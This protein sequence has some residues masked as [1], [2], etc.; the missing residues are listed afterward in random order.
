ML[1]SLSLKLQ[2]LYWKKLFIF[3]FLF[4][5]YFPAFGLN[6]EVNLRISAN[7]GKYGTEKLQIRTLFHAVQNAPLITNIA[8]RS[9]FGRFSTLPNPSQRQEVIGTTTY[10]LT[11]VGRFG[12]YP[13]NLK[14]SNHFMKNQD[15]TSLAY[16]IASW[17]KFAYSL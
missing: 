14:D 5:L 8:F 10:F 9:V 1:G 2:A 6:A 13:K 12:F 17:A 3:A 15:S 7:T 16:N 11:S 4:G